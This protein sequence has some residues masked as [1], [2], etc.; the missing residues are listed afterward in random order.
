[1]GLGSKARPSSRSD[2]D[3]K[4]FCHGQSWSRSST[5]CVA[6][7][8]CSGREDAE[9]RSR[10]ARRADEHPSK[11]LPAHCQVL[12]ARRV[13]GHELWDVLVPDQ[14]RVADPCARDQGPRCVVAKKNPSPLQATRENACGRVSNQGSAALLCAHLQSSRWN[15]GC[16]VPGGRARVC[17]C[18]GRVGF[19]ES[20]SKERLKVL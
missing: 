16:A 12:P 3:T 7:V 9:Q 20:E 6:S 13:S 17:Q 14:N 18:S 19:G 4:A 2:C 5:Q 1:M 8:L 15:D 10:F 11:D